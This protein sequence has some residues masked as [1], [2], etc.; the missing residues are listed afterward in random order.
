MSNSAQSLSHA[1]KLHQ[2]GQ[3]NEAEQIYRNVVSIEKR[4]ADAWVYLGIALF[5][6]R[7]F[8][9]SVAA[10]RKAI[11]IRHQFPIAWNNMGNSLRMLGRTEEADDC[12]ETSLQQDPHYLSALKNRGTLW[13]WSGEIERG[14]HWYQRGLE[15]SPDH[16]E[17]H[18]N[19]GVIELLR[20]NYERGWKE[21]RWR[22]KM[23]GLTRPQT[24]A[25]PW[26]GEALDGK[27]LLLYPEQGLGDAIH[28]VRVAHD[29]NRLG[30]R[31]TLQCSEKLISLF[32][33]TVES[34]GV[35][36]LV[37]DSIAAPPT[38]YQASMIEVVDNLFETTKAV[39]Y[40]NGLFDEGEGY[41]RVSDPLVQYWKRWFDEH[42]PRTQDKPLRVGL[43]WQGNP[44][45]H[46]DI[47]RS[48][49]L[50]A[51]RDLAALPI[52]LV[53]LQFGFGSEQIES[54]DF[55]SQIAELPSDVDRDDGAF[56]DTTAILSNL[57]Y[58]VTSDTAIAH[59]AGATNTRSHLLLGRVPDWRWLTSGTSTPWYPSITMHR[60]SELGDWSDVVS[61]VRET[62][63]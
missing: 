52:Q 16:A 3:I 45:H 36:G 7:L 10:Y 60:Q 59:L 22:W 15:V 21:Y 54:C 25:K 47:Y 35:D 33:S 62:L 14:M 48:L 56:T 42:L 5:D 20:G 37:I 63:A 29:L 31:V 53:S 39:P 11:D 50:D 57:D 41:L 18:R 1:W 23:P 40:G 13:I 43:N 34:L 51:F 38:D 27:S 32:S 12:F 46:A 9:E 26:R 4:N 6:Q 2:A 58:V 8:D 44:E 24:N 49:P 17:L 28:F 61:S 55:A 19:I 30:A